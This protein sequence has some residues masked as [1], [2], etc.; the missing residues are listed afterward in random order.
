MKKLI[1]VILCVMCFASQAAFSSSE[2]LTESRKS[3][4][5]TYGIM[6]GDPDGNLRENDTVTR[7]EAVK[8]L[9]ASAGID[10]ISE[11]TDS[12]TFPDVSADHWAYKYVCAAKKEKIVIGDENGN[13]NPESKVTN[14]E[15]IKMLVCILGYEPMAEARGGYPAGYN[16]AASSYGVTKGLSLDVNADM[17]R[18][19]AAN[20]IC[21]SLDLPLMMQT[22]FGDSAEYT[23]MDG[24]NGIE[25][26]TLRIR[27][28][29]KSR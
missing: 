3:D 17:I 8:M 9:L 19:D 23:I 2:E 20:A 21:N 22:G 29:E 18:R 28:D 7:A 4:L 12:D 26:I 11:I 27:L 14:E 15:F 1:C 10:G 24:K 6:V 16:V 5:R 13:F 25:K